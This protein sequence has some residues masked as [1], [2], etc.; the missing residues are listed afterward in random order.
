MQKLEGMAWRLW[1]LRL[2]GGGWAGGVCVCV[3][4]CV[5]VSVYTHLMVAE[6]LVS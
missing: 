1:E 4:V 5:C 2:D 3:C 6:C